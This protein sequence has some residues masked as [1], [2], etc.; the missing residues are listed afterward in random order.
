MVSPF[1]DIT[2]PTVTPDGSAVL[3][4]SWW[5]RRGTWHRTERS[6]CPWLGVKTKTGLPMPLMPLVPRRG[7]LPG[8]VLPCTC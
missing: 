7:A 6:H 1:D 8:P 2:L 3:G 5:T 4:A